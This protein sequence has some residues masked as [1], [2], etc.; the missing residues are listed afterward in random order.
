MVIKWKVRESVFVWE[1]RKC[2]LFFIFFSIRRKGRKKKER[3]K[4][5]KW[6]MK[7]EEIPFILFFSS[8]FVGKKNEEREKWKGRKHLLFLF[9]FSLRRKEENEER[10][11]WKRRK[12]LFFFF[13]SPLVVKK[14][15][16]KRN[17]KVF[18]RDAASVSFLHGERSGGVGVSLSTGGNYDEDVDGNDLLWNCSLIWQSH[19]RQCGRKASVFF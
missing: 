5:R 7:G 19:C 1:G 2:I 18:L 17:K 4:W 10:E 8:P 15:W 12:H 16:R 11:K 3:R 13:S 14:K 6:E 9:F